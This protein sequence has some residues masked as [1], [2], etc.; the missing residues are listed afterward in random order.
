MCG[1]F[2]IFGIDAALSCD[3]YRFSSA[4]SAISHRGPDAR[5]VKRLGERAMFGHVRLSII[6]LSEENN[7]PFSILDR[8]HVIYNGEIFNYIELRHELE[9]QGAIFRTSGDTEVLLYAYAFWGEACV[10]HFNGMWAFAIYD[11]E[12]DMLFCSRDR[13]GIKPFNYTISKGRFIFASEIKAIL[14]YQPDLVIPNYNAI[15]NYCRTSVGA[16][17]EHTWFK[18]I[19]RLQPG[20]N[21]TIIDGKI[22][23]T[24]YWHYPDRTSYARNFLEAKEEYRELF[25]DAIRLRLRSDV[26]IG[27][28]LSSGIDSNSIAYVLHDLERAEH[29]SYTSTF[30]EDR[31]MLDASLYRDAHSVDESEVASIVSKELGFKYYAVDVDLSSMLPILSQAIWYLECG[32]SS[33]AVVPLMRLM[34]RASSQVRVMLEG[35]GADELLGGYIVNVIFPT[36][37]DLIIEGKFSEAFRAIR[38][39]SETYQI[40]YAAKMFL[41]ELSNNI[42]FLTRVY[43]WKHGISRLFG[44]LLQ[45]YQRET[46]YMDLRDEEGLGF[47][48]R[49]LLRQHSGGLIN[50][51][52][53]GDALSMA[54]GVENRL[55]FMDYRLV[56]F[57]WRLPPDFKVNSGIGKYIHREAMRGIVP[58]HILDQK[59]KYGYVTPI[60]QWFKK[61]DDQYSPVNILMSRRCLDRG[62]FDKKG[63]KNLL[64]QHISGKQD[65]SLLL[66]RFLSTELWFRQFI[67]GEHENHY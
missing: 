50:L 28:T 31:V 3:V 63:V 58:D 46:D 16:Q 21:L 64:S 15:S 56:E 17:S 60:S 7:Q 37:L 27:L 13:F 42:T 10:S 8:Y 29:H 19:Y 48:N 9:K 59:R 41:R 2:G 65:Y 55:P 38:C 26:P 33:P 40:S 44:P 34:Q 11:T 25:R 22:N 6:D 18:D 36:F 12:K 66:F 35:Q 49:T 1:I 54:H 5:G 67:D 43:Q 14:S 30:G 47:L 39:Y 4:L 20:H 45:D 53:Y 23:I 61:K 57:V 62:I 24:R 32:H 52:H 51:L